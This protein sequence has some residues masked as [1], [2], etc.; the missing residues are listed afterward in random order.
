MDTIRDRFLARAGLSNPSVKDIINAIKAIPHGRPRERSA[1]GVVQGW[2]GTCSTKLLLLREMCPRLPMRMYNRVFLLTPE[3][4]RQHMGDD[5]AN[6]IPPG[7]TTDVHTY[8]KIHHDN[9][10]VLIDL[11]FPGE[12]WD[13]HSDMKLPWGEGKDFEAGDDPIASKEA[14]VQQH[15][16]PETRARLIQAI[17]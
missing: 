5:V 8:A 12:R 11:T 10:W 2:R 15:G 9:R 13:G 6:V 17:S 3:A 1:Q 4:A 7:G 16:D 14:L